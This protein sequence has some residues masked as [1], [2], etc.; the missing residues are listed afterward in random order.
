[1]HFWKKKS[2]CDYIS[3]PNDWILMI[4]IHNIS[5]INMLRLTLGQGHKVKGQGQ[6]CK[7]VKTLFLTV[8]H[9]P[10]VVY[11]CY[12]QTWLI[13]IRCWSW[14]KVRVTDHRQGHRS[15]SNI[16]FCKKMFLL[17][18]MY[19]WL[20]IILLILAKMIDFNKMLKLTKCQG[21]KVKG[22]G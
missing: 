16:Q 19:K 21:H 18:F 5:I 15:R 11:W 7:F 6:L 2:C 12:Y 9:A 20:D 1:M 8:Y 13:I 4:L 14:P 17:Y 3:W 10:L 22:Q